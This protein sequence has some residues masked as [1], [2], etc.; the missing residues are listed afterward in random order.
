MKSL[1]PTRS[2]ELLAEPADEL[3]TAGALLQGTLAGALLWLLAAALYL[4]LA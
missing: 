2:L 1:A 3:A 4:A